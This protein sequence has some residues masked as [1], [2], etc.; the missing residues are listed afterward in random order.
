MCQYAEVEH[1][2][3]G[4]TEKCTVDQ[5]EATQRLYR[6]Q[7]CHEEEYIDHS[8]RDIWVDHLCQFDEVEHDRV[9]TIEECIVDQLEVTQ[10][11]HRPQCCHEE[12]HTDHSGRD[13][14]MYNLCQY[15]VVEHD[16]VGRLPKSEP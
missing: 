5:L 8:V 11:L 15:A 10:R 12:E 3:V 14:W 7:R 6:P 1:D 2:R 9:N 4:T 16:R 13:N